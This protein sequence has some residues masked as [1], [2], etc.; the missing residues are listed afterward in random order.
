MRVMPRDRREAMFGVYAY[1]RRLD[2][3]ADGD[4]PVD[5][6]LAHLAEWRDALDR[7][8]AGADPGIPEVRAL[9]GPLQRFDLE[10]APLE[11]VVAGMEMDVR[12]EMR[13]P[14]MPALLAYCERV[15]GA[16]G[17]LAV[18]IFGATGEAAPRFALALGDALQL[19]NILR[20]IE[21]DARRD[22][23]YI[24]RE[25]LAR[26]GIHSDD[27]RTVLRDTALPHACDLLAEMATERYRRALA[28]LPSDPRPLRPA[29]I[30]LSVYARL[31]HRLRSAGWHPAVPP[32]RV[33][34]AERLWIALR[35]L[36][37]PVTWPNSI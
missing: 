22:R 6:K 32:P 14:P 7:L 9:A 36:G 8:F 5:E 4:G 16:V 19:T 35:H 26:A 15:A 10:R 24:P 37:P 31:L 34:A 25:F 28:A 21:E 1:C 27:P 13:A 17:L 23:L 29:M 11:A 2:D 3:I 30:M 33:P 20:D 18:R 12:G